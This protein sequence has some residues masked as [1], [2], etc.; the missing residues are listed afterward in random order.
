MNNNEVIR[1]LPFSQEFKHADFRSIIL[2]YAMKAYHGGKIESYVLGFVK[3]AKIMDITSA[4]PYALTLLPMIDINKIIYRQD[5]KY[6]DDYFYAFIHCVVDIQSETLI[7]PLVVE[8]PLNDSNIS[9]YGE[10]EAIITKVEYEYLIEKGIKV[11]ILDYVACGDLKEIY[12]Y[13]DLVRQLF[14]NRMKHKKTNPSLSHVFKIILN[15]LYGITMEL[16]D[17]WQL[18]D[19]DITWKGYRAGDF[20]NPIIASYITALTRTYLSRVSENIIENGGDVYLNM[21]DSIIYDGNVTLDVFSDIKT[22]GKFEPSENIED[23][24]I[25]GSGR[26][27]YK[28]E[29]NATYIVKNRGFSVLVKDKA[30]YKNMELKKSVDLP[31]RT[32]VTP[33]KATTK[34]YHI[35][36]LGSLLEDKYTIK[37]FNLGGKRIVIDENINLNKEFTK[38]KPIRLE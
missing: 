11:E 36:Q 26:Y 27:E 2:E 13:R 17:E 14:D 38:T 22:L 33:F 1:E 9:P 29:F 3:E 10:F 30:F 19:Q 23:I 18:S 15:S 8:N 4:Y 31:H 7:H 6:L 37:P 12:P 20:F 16:T 35:S 32:F 25:L 21:T 28:K 24:I 5:A 34:K